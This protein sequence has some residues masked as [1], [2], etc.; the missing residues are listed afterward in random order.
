VPFV[1]TSIWLPAI[2]RQWVPIE[3]LIDT[4]AGRTSLHP[5]D[6]ITRVG[7]PIQTLVDPSLWAKHETPGGIGGKALYF[8][9][10]AHYAFLKSDGQWH[11]MQGEIRIAQASVNNL[12]L[13][14]LLGWDILQHLPL[15]TNWGNRS[16]WLG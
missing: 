14:S 12:T 10:D 5:L 15:T 11:Q 2:Q 9:V 8:V 16:I 7:I 1:R 13:P 3:L 4:G 6:A